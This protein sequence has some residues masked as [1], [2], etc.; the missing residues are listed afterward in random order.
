MNVCEC[1]VATSHENCI[2]QMLRQF[3]LIEEENR[4]QN[5]HFHCKYKMFVKCHFEVC[6]K[7]IT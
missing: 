1:D 4:D 6:S 7:D 3:K 2:N 5:E